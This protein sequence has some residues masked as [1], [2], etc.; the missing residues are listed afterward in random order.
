MR[1]HAAYF[2]TVQR[3]GFAVLLYL[4][5][6]LSVCSGEV[7]PGKDRPATAASWKLPALTAKDLGGEEHDLLE[8]RGKVILLNFWASW[9]SPCMLEI[10]HLIRYQS[11]FGKNGLQVI[12]IG[13]DEP[14]KLGNVART[15]GIDYPVLAISPER[16]FEILKQWGNSYGILPFTVIIDRDG[17][18]ILMQQGVFA[19]QAFE[20]YVLPLL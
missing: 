5:A 2:K 11:R 8:W 15:L 14:K 19:D 16:H 20:T 10:P 12:G 3:A 1:W 6:G 7:M 9:C 17:S 4:A 13:L 18:V